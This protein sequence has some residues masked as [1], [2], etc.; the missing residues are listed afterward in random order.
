MVRKGMADAP[1]WTWSELLLACGVEQPADGPGVSGVSIDTRMLQP[2]DLFIA[3]SGDPGPGFGVRAGPVR[4]GHD[5]VQAAED[6][7]AS[8]LLTDRPVPS[9]LPALIVPDTLNGLWLIGE[10]ARQRM[11][12]KVVGITG[13][14][15]KTTARSW[16]QEMLTAQANTHASIG[17]YNNHWGVP[18]SLSRMPRGTEFGLFEIGMNHPGEIEPLARLVRPD[19][20]LVLNV[21]PAHLGQFRHLEDIR[22]EKLSIVRG[23]ADDGV[24]VVHEKISL[25]GV[26][27]PHIVT[28]GTGPS[29]TVSGRFS[30]EGDDGRIIATV[31]GQ[32]YSFRI[33]GGGEHRALTALACLAVVHAL[34]A[35][36]DHAVE[37]LDDLES[38]AGR[39][40]VIQAGGMLVVDDSYNANPASMRYAIDAVSRQ[41]GGRRIALLGEMLELGTES[42]ALH[43]GV[44][45]GCAVFDGVV[46]FGAGFS[47]A[48]ERLPGNHWGH[49]DSVDEFD[50]H[51]FVRRLQPG[52]RILVKGSNRVF[53]V[54]RFVT[55]LLQ[56]LEQRWR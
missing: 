54:N 22:R 28:F 27:H 14:S 31:R 35:D 3:L 18:L 20:A 8:A 55:S 12:G 24:L 33:R 44:L 17:S 40:N 5:F 39:G 43:A 7:G 45:D 30:P 11:E 29:A 41:A 15:G 38:P 6:A 36:P 50:L 51:D 49:Y 53:W 56:A 26:D 48:Q 47:R 25:E 2:G 19:V 1:L 10:A 46:T 21:L 52:D 42:D 13:S 32:E 34:G 16:L 37:V 23:L 9:A 4:D